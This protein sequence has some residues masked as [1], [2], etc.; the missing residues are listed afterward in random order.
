MRIFI[1]IRL[2]EQA[3]EDIE[4]ALKPFRKIHTPIKWTKQENV[5]LTLKFIGEIPDEK[6][7]P[8]ESV[9]D[10]TDFNTG[11]FDLKISGFGKFGRGRDLN[12]FWVGIE[13]NE[14]LDSIYRKI[15]NAL[16]KIG[17]EKEKRPFTPHITL[18]RNKKQFEFKPI[19]DL[20]DASANQPV[21]TSP[22]ASFQVFRSELRPA[23]PVYTVLK[24]V[25]LA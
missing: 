12:I 3:H 4:K 6:Y 24:E 16:A 13:K 10:N 14:K 5:H 19:F 11:P 8:I 20:L 17:I 25:R 21:T 18:G 1:G 22:V 15:E 2:S 9:L 7:S 23:G